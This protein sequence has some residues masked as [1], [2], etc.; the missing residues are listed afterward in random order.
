MMDVAQQHGFQNHTVDT[1]GPA[2]W[3]RP[4]QQQP[5]QQPYQTANPTSGADNGAGFW[6]SLDYAETATPPGQH[7]AQVPPAMHFSQIPPAPFAIMTMVPV[8]AVLVPSAATPV[9]SSTPNTSQSFGTTSQSPPQSS[10]PEAQQ[11]SVDSSIPNSTAGFFRARIYRPGSSEI[12]TELIGDIDAFESLINF[13][14]AGEFEDEEAPLTPE[15]I[16][17]NSSQVTYCDTS[18]ESANCVICLDAFEDGDTLRVLNCGHSF[19]LQCI[20]QW[21]SRSRQCAMCRQRVGDA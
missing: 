9:S 18:D 1:A 10:M 12:A 3:Q 20:D 5:Q 11:F 7:T 4:L 14:I 17:H 8:P 19:H 16:D 13:I 6:I 15:E 2:T 21:F